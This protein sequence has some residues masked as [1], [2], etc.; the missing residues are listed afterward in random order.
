LHCPGALVQLV[1]IDPHT[2]VPFHHHKKTTEVFHIIEGTGSMT[3]AGRTFNLSPG[4]TLTTEPNE[5]HNAINSGDSPLRYIV[6][7]TNAT[8]G[9][10]VW[11]S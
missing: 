4:D 2:E 8:E 3:V 5:L 11:L 1:V 10:S 6:F 9:D 7:K